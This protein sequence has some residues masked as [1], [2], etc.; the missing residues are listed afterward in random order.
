MRNQ[1]LMELGADD[2]W[3]RV[4]DIVGARSRPKNK[5]NIKLRLVW[6]VPLIFSSKCNC[7]WTKIL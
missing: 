7:S 2:F 4:L 3:K 5:K 6:A 1:I